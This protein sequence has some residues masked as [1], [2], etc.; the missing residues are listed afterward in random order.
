M[1]DS[2]F[3]M[4]GAWGPSGRNSWREGHR[5][6]GDA[7]E[8]AWP[9]R[10]SDADTAPLIAEMKKHNVPYVYTRPESRAELSVWF[11]AWA[12]GTTPEELRT[13]LRERESA[14]RSR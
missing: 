5:N 3:E 12:A 14:Q 11:A 7:Y 6:A 10:G 9:E 1:W 4:L 13:I 2:I 8:A